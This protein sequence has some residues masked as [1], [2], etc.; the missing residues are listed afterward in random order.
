MQRYEKEMALRESV[1]KFIQQSRK[2][3]DEC[4]FKDLYHYAKAY[5]NFDA[6]M[7]DLWQLL[8]SISTRQ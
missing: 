5:F 8:K 2:L 4:N 6:E 3:I 7:T 1:K